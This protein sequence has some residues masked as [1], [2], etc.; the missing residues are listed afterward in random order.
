MTALKELWTLGNKNI[1]PKSQL[2]LK[3]QIT[4]YFQKHS[5]TCL[6]SEMV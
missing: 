1:N 3:K 6:R 2:N 4:I 5:L